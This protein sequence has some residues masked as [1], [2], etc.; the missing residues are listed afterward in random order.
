MEGGGLLVLVLLIL[1]ILP[2]AVLVII[3]NIL[4]GTI[5]LRVVCV[6]LLYQQES[7]CRPKYMYISY[8]GL[9]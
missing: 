7:I 1:M 3:V 5:T 4:G 8:L 2:L 9:L 6:T